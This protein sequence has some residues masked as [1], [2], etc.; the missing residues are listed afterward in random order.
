MT[1]NRS[2][3]FN[4]VFKA[5]LTIILKAFAKDMQVTGRVK[6][7]QIKLA[8]TKGQDVSINAGVE[9]HLNTQFGFDLLEFDPFAPQVL[10]QNIVF[11]PYKALPSPLFIII[12]LMIYQAVQF[13]QQ[14][15]TR[16]MKKQNFHFFGLFK[17]KCS[18]SN[19]DRSI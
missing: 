9:F 5:C 8:N 6:L 16:E 12:N 17:F 1:T 4:G 14:Q 10:K 2:Q 19:I 13:S 11:L 18:I 3:R 7:C 15:D